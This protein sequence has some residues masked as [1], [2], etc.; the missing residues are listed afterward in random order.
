MLKWRSLLNRSTSNVCKRTTELRR[1]L[2][3]EHLK[4]VRTADHRRA[5]FRSAVQ[6]R[7]RTALRDLQSALRARL[8]AGDQ[9]LAVPGMDRS[10]RLGTADRP[11]LDRLTHH[12]HILEMNGESYWL[13]QRTRKRG[14]QPN[15]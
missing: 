10:P 2:T 8:N 15:S 4:Q 6:V 13:K 11:L 12:V 3:L 14:S 7:S 9:Q 5:R 1:T